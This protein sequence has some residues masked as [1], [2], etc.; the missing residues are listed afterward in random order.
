MRG[1]LPILEWSGRYGRADFEADSLAAVIVTIMLIPQSL[2]YAMLA[3]LPPQTGLYASMLPLVAYM[4]F[5]TSHALAVGPVA[6]VSLMTA[7]TLGDI[8]ATGS[9]GYLV[10]AVLLAVI[11]G[12]ILLVMGVLKLGFLAH[13]LS[14]PVISGFITASGLLIAVSQLDHL[15]GLEVSGRALP[16]LATGLW[17]ELAQ[18]N[19]L[20]LLVGGSSLAALVLIRKGLHPLLR[21]AGLSARAA[22]NLAKAGPLVVIFVSIAVVTLFD[23]QGKIAVTGDI[24]SGLPTL[25]WPAF[26]P[27]LIRTLLVPALL[28]SIIGFVESVSVGQTLAAKA[29]KHIQPDRELVG[30]GTANVAAGLSGGYPVTGGFARSVVNFDAG[31]ATPAAGGLTA[32]GI[33]L[34]TL[35]FTPYL[36]HLPKAVLAATI[37]IAVLSL[38]DLAPLKASWAYSRSDFA[39]SL[40]TIAVTLLVGV[41]AGVATG[42]LASLALYL[43]KASQPHIAEI[44]QVPGTQHFR[45]VKR[46]QVITSPKVLSL[47]IDENM[48]FANARYIEN[49]ILSRLDGNEGLAHVTMNFAS[50]SL[51]DS[52]GQAVLQSVNKMLSERGVTLNFTEL[53]GPVE[54]RL[55][56]G[57]L[58]QELS[59]NV[60][61]HQYEAMTALDPSVFPPLRQSRL[62][63]QEA[64]DG[65]HI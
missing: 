25:Q 15:L 63:I 20:T 39:A 4:I 49:F 54:D 3:G 33:A 60:Y 34:A 46:H 38:I 57:A 51:I 2:A 50:V 27:D 47:R 44:G 9:A 7:A 21:K 62:E 24:P 65:S 43:Y 37:I 48:F 42:V 29:G 11:S 52:S 19:P 55:K 26:D 58:L 10:G 5:G 13:F 1:Y 40:T 28:I 31:A 59:G 64:A 36:Y 8:A 30:L 41:E 12:V 17:S 23:M 35:F 22:G 56:R 18:V 32:L 61:L 14:Q 16:E 6:V 45:N 53:K